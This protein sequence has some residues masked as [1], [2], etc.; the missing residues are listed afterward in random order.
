MGTLIRTKGTRR[1]IRHLTK[2][3]GANI[4]AY[5]TVSDLFRSS[6]VNSVASKHYLHYLSFGDDITPNVPTPG[7]P[8]HAPP[9]PTGRSLTP[10]H[11]A[12]HHANLLKRWQYYL[13]NELT[14]A[15]HDAIRAAIYTALTDR[16]SGGSY[17]FTKI[18]F[19]CI[20]GPIQLAACATE[21]D[22]NDA[23]DTGDDPASKYMK[24]VLVT[25]RT[26]AP[27]QPDAQFS[28]KGSGKK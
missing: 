25:G 3:F 11:D 13:F 6:T 22:S 19:D 27:D 10:K 7:V 26:N 23:N 2:E 17:T 16:D 20:E 8:A 12:T 5:R 28:S 4:G 21:Y 15:N 18:V 24:I 9:L 1:I 14:T